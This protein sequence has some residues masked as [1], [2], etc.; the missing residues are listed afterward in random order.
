[1]V[2]GLSGV[3]EEVTR[4]A[5]YLFGK[6]LKMVGCI[7]SDDFRMEKTFTF[8][9]VDDDVCVPMRLVL[10]LIASKMP[11]FTGMKHGHTP[12]SRA[13]RATRAWGNVLYEI[14]IQPAQEVWKNETAEAAGYHDFAAILI[15]DCAVRQLMLVDNFGESVARVKRVPARCTHSGLG[16]VW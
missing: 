11:L 10:C 16:D 12:L 3:G 6:E 8:I 9:F 2:D 4:L 7:A 14:N 13:L 15:F 5:L 1:M